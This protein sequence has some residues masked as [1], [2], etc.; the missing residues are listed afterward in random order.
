MSYITHESKAVH[1]FYLRA[2]EKPIVNQCKTRSRSNLSIS[3]P[4]FEQ[5]FIISVCRP[6]S[7]FFEQPFII[8][9]RHSS[10][11]LINTMEEDHGEAEMGEDSWQMLR[12]S[13]ALATSLCSSRSG[14]SW[15]GNVVVLALFFLGRGNVPLNVLLSLPSSHHLAHVGQNSPPQD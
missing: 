5:P 14:M 1:R 9:V 10:V 7:P 12:M 4:F 11:V 3:S 13:T 2:S 6:T 15:G 8:S